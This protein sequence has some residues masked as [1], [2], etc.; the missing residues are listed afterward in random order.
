MCVCL[1]MCICVREK[2]TDDFEVRKRPDKSIECV[3]KEGNDPYGR[4]NNT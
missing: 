4:G 1:F 3:Y 2:G